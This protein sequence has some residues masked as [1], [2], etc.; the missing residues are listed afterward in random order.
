MSQ[1][2]YES[3]KATLLFS[4]PIYV[5]LGT[6]LGLAVLHDTCIHL[7]SHLSVIPKVIFYYRGVAVCYFLPHLCHN[8]L[9]HYSFDNQSKMQEKEKLNDPWFPEIFTSLPLVN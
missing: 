1:Y 4:F 7:W 8:E 2:A 6:E 3:Q 5:I 9:I